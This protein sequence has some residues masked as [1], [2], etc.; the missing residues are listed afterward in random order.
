ML[1]NVATIQFIHREWATILPSLSLYVWDFSVKN[2]T[3]L[4]SIYTLVAAVRKLSQAVHS[5][6]DLVSFS[7]RFS[8]IREENLLVRYTWT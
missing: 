5:N 3:N 4:T 7:Q 8:T 2:D 1:G 6:C